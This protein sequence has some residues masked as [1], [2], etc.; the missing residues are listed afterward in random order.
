M[1]VQSR[2]TIPSQIGARALP[3]AQSFFGLPMSSSIYRRLGVLSDLPLERSDQA[4]DR[5][6]CLDYGWWV[7]E[8]SHNS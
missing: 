5:G 2:G 4:E 8:V 3:T 7:G 6:M 1:S